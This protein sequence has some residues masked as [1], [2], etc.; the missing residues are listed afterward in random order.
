MYIREK[1]FKMKISVNI[2]INSYLLTRF[3]SVGSVLSIIYVSPSA[4]SSSDCSLDDP[5]VDGLIATMVFFCTG[6]MEGIA[7]GTLASLSCNI[8]GSFPEGT[9]PA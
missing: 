2:K 6:G 1:A 5:L 8:G 4:S 3:T 7:G 9:D